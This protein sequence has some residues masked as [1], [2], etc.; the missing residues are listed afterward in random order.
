MG[1]N[2]IR[3]KKIIVLTTGTVKMTV[4]GSS[5]ILNMNVGSAADPGL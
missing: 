5:S 2:R 3:K 4:K 1:L